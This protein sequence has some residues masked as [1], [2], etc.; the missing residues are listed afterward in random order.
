MAVHIRPLSSPLIQWLVDILSA[1]AKSR[2][3]SCDVLSPGPDLKLK[4]ASTLAVDSQRSC[5]ISQESRYMTN[6]IPILSVVDVD[7]QLLTVLQA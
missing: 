5:Q 1:E 4:E 2:Q 3:V 7:V 6:H